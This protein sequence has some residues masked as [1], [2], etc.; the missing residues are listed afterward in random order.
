MKTD[1]IR[2]SER[3]PYVEGKDA[4]NWDR[5]AVWIVPKKDGIPQTDQEQIQAAAVSRVITTNGYRGGYTLVARPGEHFLL[6]YPGSRMQPNKDRT[7]WEEVS[8]HHYG[9]ISTK[10]FFQNYAVVS[11][12][13][14]AKPS[15]QEIASYLAKE[16]MEEARTAP[17]L[18]HGGN[19]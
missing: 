17:G 5:D 7:G 16:R 4:A 12:Q 19:A 2:A 18:A 13:G 8:T 15:E 3:P 14:A 1:H 10:D 9:A 6:K 11:D